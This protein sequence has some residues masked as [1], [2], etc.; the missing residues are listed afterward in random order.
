LL[1][2]LWSVFASLSR[3]EERVLA[4]GAGL[5]LQLF[6]CLTGDESAMELWLLLSSERH[7]KHKEGWV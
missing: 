7:D 2:G 6:S 5:V 1:S 4:S 3:W